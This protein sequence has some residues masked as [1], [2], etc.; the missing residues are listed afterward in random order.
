MDNRDLAL[1][2]VEEVWEQR[3][4]D[5]V[6]RFTDP[7][8][9]DH[10]YLPATAAGHARM[11]HTFCAAFS[12]SRHAVEHIVTGDEL[13]LMRLRVSATHTGTFREHEA[14]GALIDVQ[15]YRSFRFRE[16]R[17]VEHW[18]LLDT[19]TLLRQIGA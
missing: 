4:P 7:A 12:A 3:T 18:A 11:V 19:A 2:F 17:I 6:F 5:A 8:F 13:V 1:R 15:Q 9:V 14:R 10:A 16:G